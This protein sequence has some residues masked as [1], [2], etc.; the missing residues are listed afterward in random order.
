[1][2]SESVIHPDPDMFAPGLGKGTHSLR[3]ML[4]AVEVSFCLK[5]FLE[6]LDAV[7]LNKP[8]MFREIVFVSQMSAR[9]L[10]VSIKQ[11]CGG[12]QFRQFRPFLS[13]WLASCFLCAFVLT[14]Y[15]A[16]VRTSFIFRN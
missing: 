7:R 13:D 3:K 5:Q 9:E 14:Y 4:C 8:K 11:C 15:S 6:S 12:S 2:H 1:M 10:Q 16:F